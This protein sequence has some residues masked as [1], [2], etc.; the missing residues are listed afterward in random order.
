MKLSTITKENIK[1]TKNAK[2]FQESEAY[3]I[4]NQKRHTISLTS[5][6]ENAGSHEPPTHNAQLLSGDHKI[7]VSRKIRTVN[8]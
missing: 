8:V 6:S 2:L 5:I 4:R 3:F 1:L 7:V